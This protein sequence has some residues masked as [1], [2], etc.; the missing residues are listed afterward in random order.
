VDPGADTDGDGLPDGWEMLHFGDLDEST[1]DD[2]DD[3]GWYNIT[4]YQRG[5]DPNVQQLAPPDLTLIAA[6]PRLWMR[7]DAINPF[8]PSQA[9]LSA[10]RTAGYATE[11][12]MVEGSTAL[13]NVALTYTFTGDLFKLNTVKSALATTTSSADT[14]VERALAF[15][16]VYAGLTPAERTTYAANLISSGYTV[17]GGTNPAKNMYMNTGIGAE[18]AA[19]IA[20][21]AAAGDDPSAQDLFDRA[22]NA[23][24][25]FRGITGD[26]FD[27]SNPAEWPGR[28]G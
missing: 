16:W 11:R 14:L 22:Y 23:L 24:L 25:E 10:R 21:L 18:R 28:A 7:P 17:R 15:D 12:S 27:M 8:V 1:Y 20:A 26:G 4:E 6:H 9:E 3:D 5:L 19:A 13:W 2:P